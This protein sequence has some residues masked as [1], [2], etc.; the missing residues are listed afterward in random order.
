MGPQFTTQF[1]STA[2]CVAR[3]TVVAGQVAAQCASAADQ[4]GCLQAGLTKAAMSLAGGGSATGTSSSGGSSAGMS[5]AQLADTT[6][7]QTCT[8]AKAQLGKKFPFATAAACTAKV[9]PT[10][11]KLATA[12]LARCPTGAAAQA[13]ITSELKKGAPALQ[14]ALAIKKG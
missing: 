2:G 1:G 3:V 14:A 8:A 5:A 11:L 12:A 10:A 6:A 4:Q 7:S 13:C 9:R